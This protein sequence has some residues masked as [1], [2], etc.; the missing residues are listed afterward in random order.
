MF[1]FSERWLVSNYSTDKLEN[2]NL[3]AGDWASIDA[4]NMAVT[5]SSK[6]SPGINLSSWG[7]PAIAKMLL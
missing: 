4:R 1:S 2:D 3:V 7:N 5:K 6:V